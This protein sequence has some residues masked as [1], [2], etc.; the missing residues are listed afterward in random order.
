MNGQTISIDFILPQEAR[1]ETTGPIWAEVV[2]QTGPHNPPNP[3]GDFPYSQYVVFS[4]GTTAYLLD[5]NGRQLDVPM[6]DWTGG[7]T[8]APALTLPIIY[9]DHGLA[10]ADI[11]AFPLWGTKVGGVHYDIVLPNTGERIYLGRV[12]LRAE[13]VNPPPPEVPVESMN[14]IVLVEDPPLEP[15]APALES[16]PSTFAIADLGATVKAVGGA[17]RFLSGYGRIQPDAG[18]S[19]SGLVVLGYRNSGVLVGE[20]VI[21]DSAPISAG[22]VYVEVTPDGRTT[23]IVV[24]NPNLED[25]TVT[26]ELRDMQG[27]LSRAG[28]FTLRGRSSGCSPGTPCNQLARFLDQDPFSSGGDVKGT[29]TLVSSAPVAMFAARWSATGGNSGDVLVTSLP[30]IDLSVAPTQEIQVIPHFMV[31]NGRTTELVMVNPTGTT[32]QG[33]ARFVD[34]YGGVTYLSSDGSNYQSRFQYSIAPHSSQKVVIAKA[35][36]GSEFGSVRV[37]PTDGPAP[38]PFVIHSYAQAGVTNFDIAVPASMGTAFRMYGEQLPGE[39]RAGI[40]ISNANDVAGTVWI[41]LSGLDGSL[42]GSTSFSLQPSGQIVDYLDSLIPSV[43][44][45]AVQGVMRITT[46]LP[47]ISVVGLRARQ[48]ERQQYVLSAIP[49][50]QED[51]QPLSQERFFPYWMNGGGFD[52]QIVLFS[53][54]SGQSASGTFSLIRA[55]GI[56]LD[57]GLE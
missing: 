56:P 48:N 34:I 26:F 6:A 17:G 40:A 32:L 36:R 28:Q 52:T 46:D 7:F 38:A 45:R 27:N 37:T 43:A 8:T 23:Q 25:A 16:P 22:R 33:V 10:G 1:V 18:T 14:P 13:P 35:L 20:T 30:V 51:R 31:G 12:G 49:A 2:L 11:V 57:L 24:A 4:E 19:P 53:G 29:L 54:R 39:L 15:I 3:N 21:P 41:S 50:V 42:L 55:D 44:D 9:T 5:E 47:A